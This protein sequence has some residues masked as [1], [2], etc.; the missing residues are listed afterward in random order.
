MQSATFA[1]IESWCNLR[2]PHSSLGGIST[3]YD[4]KIRQSANAQ[5]A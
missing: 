5:A 1:G 2:R 3:A 4:P